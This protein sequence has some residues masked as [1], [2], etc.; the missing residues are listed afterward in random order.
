[1]NVDVSDNV[2]SSSTLTEPFSEIH[3]EIQALFRWNPP[4]IRTRALYPFECGNWETTTKTPS[5]SFHHKHFDDRLVLQH[6]KHLPSLTQDLATNVDKALLVASDT[7]AHSSYFMTTAEWAEE[8][9]E[10]AYGCIPANAP[11]GVS[12]FYQCI[13]MHCSRVVS[14]LALHPRAQVPRWPSLLYWNNSFNPS[15]YP[16]MDGEQASI[17]VYLWNPRHENSTRP[18]C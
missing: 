9:R 3:R 7:L 5:S 2:A 15:G 17:V 8:M 18:N 1:M 4:R 11:F 6:I 14:A 12:L 13:T 16:V 10:S